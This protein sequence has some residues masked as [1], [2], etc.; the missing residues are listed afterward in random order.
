MDSSRSSCRPTNRTILGSD[1]SGVNEA[2]GA[3]VTD[4]PVGDEVYYTPQVFC[5]DGSYAE[6]HVADESIVAHTP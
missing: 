5:R 3:A 1:V 2:I 4:F 6:Y